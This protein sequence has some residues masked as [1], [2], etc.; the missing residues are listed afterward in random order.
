MGTIW[1]RREG[2]SPQWDNDQWEAWGWSGD[3]WEIGGGRH[4]RRRRLWERQNNFCMLLPSLVLSSVPE[5]YICFSRRPYPYLHTENMRIWIERQIKSLVFVTGIC[6]FICHQYSMLRPRVNNTSILILT[7]F[8]WIRIRRFF[9]NPN[10]SLTPIQIRI[11]GKKHIF[12]PKQNIS[13]KN[14][15]V[16]S[17]C[18][19]NF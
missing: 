6:G 3:Q 10:S 7:G 5:T 16:H 17:S 9:V 2:S 4:Q 11:Q 18:F 14:Y 12:W 13:S 8:V 19:P 1:H 15:S